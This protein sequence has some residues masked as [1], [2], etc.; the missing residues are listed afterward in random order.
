MRVL[1]LTLGTRGDVQPFLALGRALK[2]RGHEV[3]VCTCCGM[4]PFVEENGLRYAYLNNDILELAGGEVGRRAVSETG[5]LGSLRWTAEA[6][7]L[8]KPIF[9]RALAEEW[10]A[11]QGAEVVVYHPQ[12]V[13]GYHIA[14][15][16][17]IPGVMADPLPMWVPTAAF[18]NLAAPDPGFGGR[19]NRMTYR[20]MSL[21]TRAMYGSVVTRW[22][23]EALGLPRRPLFADE[24]ARA[25]GR[26]VPVLLGFSP[27]VVPPPFDWPE[28]VVVTGYWFLDEAP[29]W[30]P[31]PGLRD[32]L[33]SGPPPV[34]VGFG[35][36]AGRDP[37]RTTRI[38]L[39]A[40]ERTG[41]RGILVMGWGGLGCPEA[42][43]GIYVA[44][45]VPYDWLLPRVAA[46]VHHGGAGTT[47]VAL[48][49]GKPSVV[50][51][52]VADQPFWGRRVAALGVGP[53]PIPQRKLNATDLATAIRTATTDPEMQRRAADLGARLRAEDGTAAAATLIEQAVAGW[54]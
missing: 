26:P 23:K 28:S 12:A 46:V 31:P 21:L 39:E 40:M 2:G 17:G 50:C 14:E 8:F 9:R 7:R 5:V 18:P 48:R 32:F 33:D 44:E 47:A 29:G 10:Q 42:P 34:L 3:T 45:S 16:L 41:Q 4:A 6:A 20:A 36:M 51:P 15:A 1:L 52:F 38:V 43:A 30:E 35:S 49:A 13:G 37:A 53:R 54:R 25:D 24:L 22:R 19:Y 27:S 11:A